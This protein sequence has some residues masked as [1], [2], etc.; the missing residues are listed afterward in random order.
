MA[1]VLKAQLL[2]TLGE[3]FGAIS[4]LP[5]SQSLFSLGDDA[6]RI[7]FR[8][9]KVHERGRTFFGLREIDLRQLEGHNSFLCLLLDDGTPPV[10]IPFADFEGVFRSAEPAN[11]GQYKVQII[12][13]EDSR[14]LYIARKGRF[15]IEGYIGLDSLERSISADRFRPAHDLSHSQVQTLLAGVGNMKGLG[16]WI[17]DNDVNRLD[18][19]LT[20]RFP[21]TGSLPVG[22]GDVASILAEVD[23]VWVAPGSNRIEAL[24]EVEHSTPV[25]SGLLR[26]NDV[27]LT[28][29]SV[30]RFHIV[31]NEV[32]RATFSRQAFRPTF[33]KSGLSE[34]VS[35]LEYTNV[36]DWHTRL[37][38]GNVGNGDEE[39]RSALRRG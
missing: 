30:N 21:L 20:R 33:R 16:V 10:F 8:Y 5:D 2:A 17:P 3:R 32:R 35:F 1:N 4:R 29:P 26:F 39:N 25:Y 36:F 31:S 19:S 18:W 7:Y 24:F 15:S 37:A 27:L 22:F 14:Q 38:K 11:D 23:V 12:S 6:A 28:E 9:S 13:Q 34:L